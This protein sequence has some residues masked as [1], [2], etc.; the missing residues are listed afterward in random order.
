MIRELRLEDVDRVGAIWL[1]ASLQAHHFVSEQFWRADHAT[2]TTE[3]LP[4]AQGHVHVTAG[5]IDGFITLRDGFIGC[6]FVE[7]TSQRRGIGASLL[8]YVKQLHTV[9]RLKVY[10]QNPD[11]TRFYEAHGFRVIGE[12]IC[13]YTGCGEL[14]ME[15]SSGRSGSR[16]D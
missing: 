12:S 2:M 5:T 13:P 14:E 7:P 3:I 9:L 15:W 1:E 6:L 4:N 16:P 11:A 8:C 10:K